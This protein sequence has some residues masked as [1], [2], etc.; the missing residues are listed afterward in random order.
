MSIPASQVFPRR[1]GPVRVVRDVRTTCPANRATARE[2]NVR[3]TSRT[4][5]TAALMAASSIGLS[6]LVLGVT[7]VAS[8]S[9]TEDFTFTTDAGQTDSVTGTLTVP[10]G[11]CSI[12]WSVQGGSGGGSTAGDDGG[13]GTLLE[14]TTALDGSATTFSLFPG[15]G[16][17]DG[18]SDAGTFGTGGSNARGGENG[19]NG[20][21]YLDSNG[22]SVYSGGGGAASTV[23][24][25]GS[26][27]LSAPGGDGGGA[28][29][30]SG[31]GAP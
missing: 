20:S 21:T 30:G 2:T 31:G 16:G 24:H 14:G 10:A 4:R 5:R 28:P 1:H 9:D 7:G 18:D 3:I 15:T 19:T 17:A 8:A 22:D 13:Y 11:Y 12:D 25:N 27:F 29:A 23:V 6:T 26:T